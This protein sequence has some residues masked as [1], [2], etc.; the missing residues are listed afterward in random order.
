MGAHKLIVAQ[1]LAAAFGGPKE[2]KVR[3][4][5][6]KYMQV[7]KDG[8]V[9]L[10][11]YRCRA[12]RSWACVQGRS[13]VDAHVGLPVRFFAVLRVRRLRTNRFVL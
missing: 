8:A 3:E 9:A 4:S 13:M 11:M 10:F 7:A 6:D 5:F 12:D 1:F 2:Y